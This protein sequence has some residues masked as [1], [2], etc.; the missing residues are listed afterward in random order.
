MKLSILFLL[1]I[2]LLVSCTKN[3]ININAPNGV[4]LP[5]IGVV[6]GVLH[7]QSQSDFDCITNLSNTKRASLLTVSIGEEFEQFK[8]GNI[9]PIDSRMVGNCIIPVEVADNNKSFF[10]L[11]NINGVISIGNDT[12]RLDCCND[13]L[14]VISNLDAVDQSKY[15]AF[16]N[17]N[18][19]NGYIGAF[20]L[21]IDVL[22]AVS[23]GYR[24]MPI[25]PNTNDDNGFS[26]NM[27]FWLKPFR[28]ILYKLQL[29]LESIQK[30][31]FP[32]ANFLIKN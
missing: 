8:S 19:A 28:L 32:K 12:Y 23:L 1:F 6:N 2:T 21:Q 11:L 30:K 25:S 10:D 14:F 4:R 22:D 26:Q 15:A 16:L 5:K 31:L 20:P 17:A 29:K 24:T 18:Q 9:I 27:H 13:K 7:F 3:V